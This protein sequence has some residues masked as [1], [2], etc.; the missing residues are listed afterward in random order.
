[1]DFLF[2]P[3]NEEERLKKRI[4]EYYG[5]FSDTTRNKLF[6]KNIER[7]TSVY[8]LLYPKQ[9]DTLLSKNVSNVKDSLDVAGEAIRQALLSKNLIEKSDLL[10]SGEDVRKSLESRNKIS[11]DKD[12]LLSK[13]ARIRENLLSKNVV[14]EDPMEGSD[15]AR[16]NLVAKNKQSEG[17]D[18]KLLSDSQRT[19]ESNIAKNIPNGIDPESDLLRDSKETRNFNLAKTNVYD[20]SLEQESKAHRKSNIHK[21]VGGDSL[22]PSKDLA[23]ESEAVRQGLVAKNVSED[24]LPLDILFE[25]ARNVLLA[26]GVSDGVSLLE[27]SDAFRDALIQKNVPEN[28]GPIEEVFANVRKGLLAANDNGTTSLLEDSESSRKENLKKNAINP[29]SLEQFS[30]SIRE[31]LLAANAPVNSQDLVGLFDSVRNGLLSANQSEN[32]DLLNLFNQERQNLL[33]FNKPNV[34]DLESG[35]ARFRDDAIS[36]N[37]PNVTDL[38]SGSVSFRDAALANNSPNVTD[39]ES[40]SKT[41][42]NDLLAFNNPKVTDLESGSVTFRSDLLSLNNPNV[43]NL[44]TDSVP[45]RSGLLAANVPNPSDIETDSVPFRDGLLSLNVP[46]PSDIESDSVPFRTGLLA[47]NVPNPSDIETDSVPFRDGLLAANVPSNS[48]IENDSVPFRTGLLAANVP[49]SSD[50][51]T[52]SVPYRDNLTAAN[53]PNPSDIATDS[54][55]FRTGLLSANVPG[56]S[57]LIADS[58]PIRLGLLSSNSPSSSDLLVDSDNLR[59]QLLSRN[60]GG[61]LGINIAAAGTSTFLGVS[62]V[63]TQG[64]LFRALLLPRNKYRINR[65]EYQGNEILLDSDVSVNARKDLSTKNFFQ[66]GTNEYSDGTERLLNSEQS[67]ESREFYAY[68]NSVGMDY[69]LTTG[70]A[71]ALSLFGTGTRP[72]GASFDPGRDGKFYGDQR[73]ISHPESDQQNNATLIG[74]VTDAIRRV[75]ISK[76]A[77]AITGNRGLREFGGVEYLNNLSLSP[78]VDSN[79]NLLPDLFQDLI[80]KSVGS[81]D[82]LSDDDFGTPTTDVSTIV[83]NNGKYFKADPA[84]MLSPDKSG[85]NEGNPKRLAA[86]QVVGNPFDDQDFRT[87]TRGV[88]RVIN[89]IKGSDLEFASNYDPQNTKSYISGMRGNEVKRTNQRWTIANPYAP[90]KAKKL[91]FYFEN[92]SNGQ[93][94][95]LPPYITSFQHGSTANWNEVNFLGRPEPLYTYNNSKRSGSISFYVLTDYATTVDIGIDQDSQQVI[96]ETFTESFNL[97]VDSNAVEAEI[98]QIEQDITEINTQLGIVED[99]G[100]KDI[101]ERNKAE[102]VA[103]KNKLVR[104]SKSAERNKRRQPNGPNYSESSKFASNIYTDVITGVPERENGDIVSKPEDTQ[105]RLAYMK[106][107]LMFQPAYFSGDQNDF[108]NRIEFLEKMCRPS[109]NGGPGFSFINP[110]VC[111][112]HLGDWFNHDL[113]ID[114]VDYD[115]TDAPWTL[116]TGGRVQPMWCQVTVSFNIIGR[117]KHASGDAL[118]STDRGGFFSL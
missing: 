32:V 7:P 85:D 92:Y 65:K 97:R 84:D 3:N 111:H 48:D 64:I 117:Y 5:E 33:A 62:R 37:S 19:R 10:T 1:M 106:Q 13:S 89:L 20:S 73:N 28:R 14:K 103:T 105:A 118:T 41:F 74:S 51:A 61:L 57:N 2:D 116:G 71:G 23:K 80:Q 68:V 115:Y 81:F 34:T 58:T 113:I 42:R 60:T 95:Y 101:L 27:V 49:G 9:R 18:D 83:N 30:Q 86:K 91:N 12:S 107:N 21:N 102:L 55:P 36:K 66:L 15:Q 43:T 25:S 100:D 4:E 52:D 78:Q 72:A 112:M 67:V 54:V 88:K 104:E 46:N 45:F 109:R 38:E 22:D 31:G 98:K 59:K 110:P 29:T 75:N 90:E 53:V 6:A 93:R 40:N 96:T 56:S 79:G 39:L 76:N 11:K 114:S 70:N 8:D 24:K 77:Y 82:D 69:S 17:F 44:E 16:R 87:G 94:L 50:I 108:L 35:S 47:A 99:K 63:L 26:K